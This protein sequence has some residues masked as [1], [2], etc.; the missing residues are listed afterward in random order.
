MSLTRVFSF[1]LVAVFVMACSSD[2]VSPSLSG[3][4][5]STVQPQ[6]GPTD[7]AAAAVFLG[8]T[9]AGA[10][11]QT[12]PYVRVYVAVAVNQLTGVWRITTKSDAAAWFQ[13]DAS[14]SEIAESGIMLVKSVD[15]DNTVTGV[16]DLYFPNAGHIN[17]DFRATFRPNNILCG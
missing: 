17:T 15:S 4:A 7:G 5:Y 1:S 8:P 11:G 2:S 6:C 14:T 10:N 16:V 9:Q 3:F 13:S 12:A